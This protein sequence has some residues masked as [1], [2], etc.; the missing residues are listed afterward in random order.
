MS[1]LGGRDYVVLMQELLAMGNKVDIFYEWMRM[2][3]LHNKSMMIH[4]S[5]TFRLDLILTDNQMVSLTM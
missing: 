3:I 1:R 4:C 5:A 2:D